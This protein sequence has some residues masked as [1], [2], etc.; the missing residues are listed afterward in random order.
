MNQCR[1][2]EITGSSGR[3]TGHEGYLYMGGLPYLSTSGRWL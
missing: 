3:F 2:N 1:E